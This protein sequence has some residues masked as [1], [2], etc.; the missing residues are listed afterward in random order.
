[1]LAMFSCRSNNSIMNNKRIS[2]PDGPAFDPFQLQIL[3]AP[4]F[5]DQQATG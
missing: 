5:L 4:L 2:D 3:I 1:M